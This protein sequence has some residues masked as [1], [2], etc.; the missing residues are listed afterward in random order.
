MVQYKMPNLKP[1]DNVVIVGTG[2]LGLMAIQLTKAV[3]GAKIIA[4]D[5]NDQN[6]V[7]KKNGADRVHKFKKR[8]SYKSG[9]GV[10][11]QIGCRRSNCNFSNKSQSCNSPELLIPTLLSLLLQMQKVPLIMI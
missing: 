10:N 7:A 1:N 2:G 5:I 8:E 9:Y 11:R 3:T 4:M 6:Y